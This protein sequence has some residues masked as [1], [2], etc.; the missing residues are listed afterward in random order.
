MP[1][2]RELAVEDTA[3]DAVCNLERVALEEEA[4]LGA[5]VESHVFL[6]LLVVDVI[7]PTAVDF[8]S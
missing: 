5:T 7:G 2:L 1:S 4:F 3:T 8:V 6:F